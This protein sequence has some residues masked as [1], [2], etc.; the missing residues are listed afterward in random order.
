MVM[1]LLLTGLGLFCFIEE[2][3]RRKK[4]DETE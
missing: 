4:Y 2:D 3:Y 1:S